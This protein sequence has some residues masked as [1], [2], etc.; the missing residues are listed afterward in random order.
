MPRLLSQLR[1]PPQSPKTEDCCSVLWE[2]CV[3]GE[4]CEGCSEVF[5]TTSIPNAT[6][7]EKMPAA[8]AAAEV[9]ISCPATRTANLLPRVGE[10]K[11]STILAV[12][13]SRDGRHPNIFGDFGLV[14]IVPV[15]LSRF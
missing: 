5:V 4:F 8:H 15:S 14:Q 7:A 11:R 13:L 3:T 2:D 12:T 6:D 9:S 10:P 1:K